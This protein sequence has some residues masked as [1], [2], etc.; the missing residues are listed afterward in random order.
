[1]FYQVN[2][3]ATGANALNAYHRRDAGIAAANNNLTGI[4]A[5]R[6]QFIKRTAAP[7][8]AAEQETPPTAVSVGIAAIKRLAD[9]PKAE[10]SVI[11]KATGKP[12]NGSYADLAVFERSE[13]GRE[14][15]AKIKAA[16]PDRE[17]A[18]SPHNGRNYIYT[19]D[20]QHELAR[21]RQIEW[22]REYGKTAQPAA[23]VEISDEGRELATK[24]S[25]SNTAR[26]VPT[27]LRVYSGTDEAP[28]ELKKFFDNEALEIERKAVK[29]ANPFSY[30]H[31]NDAMDY[32]YADSTLLYA[33]YS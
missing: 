9:A 3:G 33:L 25:K 18:T 28:A 17:I 21:I 26:P 23:I 29:A 11:Q 30:T 12:R 14:L 24:M 5:A 31:S 22:E 6:S 13:E 1:M 4:R 15:L 16:D 27:E 19:G 2:A 10:T 7:A 20:V 32:V 8:D